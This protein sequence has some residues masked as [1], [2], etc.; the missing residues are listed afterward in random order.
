ME[1]FE[2]KAKEK[3]KLQFKLSCLMEKG[4]VFLE[5]III[6][7]QLISSFRANQLEKIVAWKSFMSGHFHHQWKEFEK[8]TN[9]VQWQS[10]EVVQKSPSMLLKEKPTSPKDMS[11]TFQNNLRLRK[12]F[13]KKKIFNTMWNKNFLKK[14]DLVN[15]N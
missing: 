11:I 1:K 4:L 2:Q 13:W 9:T 6:L 7:L 12:R 10:L 5:A 15:E 3:I 8:K 14:R